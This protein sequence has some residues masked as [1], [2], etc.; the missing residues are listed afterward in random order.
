MN[1]QQFEDHM[2]TMAVRGIIKNSNIS[3]PLDRIKLVDNIFENYRKVPK[4]PK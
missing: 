3:S 2:N 1:K 4:R